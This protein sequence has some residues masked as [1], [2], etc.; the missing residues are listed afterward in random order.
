MAQEPKISVV[1]PVYG[2]GPCLEELCRRLSQTLETIT[3]QYEILLVDDRSPDN[4][5]ATILKLHEEYTQVR[6]I[7][8]SRNFGQHIAISAGL[9]EAQ[10]DYVVVLDCDLQDPPEH[11]PP[12]WRSCRRV[13]MS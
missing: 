6:G 4:A 12:C 5:W 10:G 2:C 3:T 9:A 13:G 11:F 1:V 7:R 8:L